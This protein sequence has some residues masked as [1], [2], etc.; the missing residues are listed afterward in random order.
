V[1]FP[2]PVYNEFVIRC[3]DPKTVNQK[4]EAAGVIGGYELEKDYPE[5]RNTLLFCATEMLTK[6]DIDRV[7]S[8]VAQ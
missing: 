7:L 4:L 1:V 3:P 6:K 5:L 2:A 8:I